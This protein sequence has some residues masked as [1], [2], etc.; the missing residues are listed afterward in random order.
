MRYVYCFCRGFNW[1]WIGFRLVSGD[2]VTIWNKQH[3]DTPTEKQNWAEQ[4]SEGGSGCGVNQSLFDWDAFVKEMYI[5]SKKRLTMEDFEFRH[6][7]GC[8]RHIYNPCLSIIKH[9]WL[10]RAITHRL[11]IK[12]TVIFRWIV[13]IQVFQDDPNSNFVY[14]FITNFQTTRSNAA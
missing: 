13:I 5:A 1:K 4:S 12:I 8:F 9:L 6:S 11:S 2:L 3:I 14:R 10:I 7:I